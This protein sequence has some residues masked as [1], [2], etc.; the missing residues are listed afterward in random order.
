M[1]LSVHA[2][3]V[4]PFDVNCY[5]V[6]HGGQCLVIDPGFDDDLIQS[7]LQQNDLRVTGFLLTHGHVD[8]ISALTPLS[9]AYPDAPILIHQL[10]ACWA[11]SETNQLQPWYTPPAAPKQTLSTDMD[12]TLCNP[13]TFEIFKTP[14]HTPGGVCFYFPQEKLLF[15]GD[16]LFKAGYGRTDLTGG[17][18][19]QLMSSLQRL[20]TLPPETEVFPG[21]GESSTVAEELKNNPAYQGAF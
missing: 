8:H 4:G 11:F 16:T 10:D 19:E 5:V 13:F 6:A 21:H 9:A 7:H 14:G 18:I 20:A 2:L 12:V 1:N 3:T 17:N 15:T